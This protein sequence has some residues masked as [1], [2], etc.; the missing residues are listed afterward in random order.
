[1]STMI[2]VH[3]FI[4]ILDT[5]LQEVIR[6]ANVLTYSAN[7]NASSHFKQDLSM[8]KTLWEIQDLMTH[9]N[10]KYTSDP[11]MIYTHRKHKTY[12]LI[13][14]KSAH[15]TIYFPTKSD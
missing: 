13:I 10:I 3:F 1:M 6:Y 9:K 11:Y 14:L 15:I 7:W 4:T 5:K 8:H 2:G 12:K